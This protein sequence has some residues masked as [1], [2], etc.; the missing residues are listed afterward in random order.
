MPMDADIIKDV[1]ANYLTRERLMAVA[2][3]IG[4][5]PGGKLRADVL[6][7]HGGNK[8]K[9]PTVTIVEVKS[10]VADFKS[11]KKWHKYLDYCNQFYWA[12][13]CPTYRKVKHL[14]PAGTGVMLIGN[15]GGIRI[16]RKAQVRELDL[17]TI[18]N[19]SIRMNYRSADVTRHRVKAGKTRV[20]VKE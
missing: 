6:A 18:L 3:E 16:E 14:I 10:S 17:P 9:G 2:L 11:D 20:A 5:C 4:I 8:S 1:A 7:L 13:D 12:M 15:L 19:L